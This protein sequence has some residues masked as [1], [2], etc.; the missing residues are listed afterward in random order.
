MSAP[1]NPS[2]GRARGNSAGKCAACI[3]G[4]LDGLPPH[5]YILTG[6]RE[7]QAAANP[8]IEVDGTP[9]SSAY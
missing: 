6:N 5:L 7:E 3:Y 9:L 1:P 4:G 8:R 2:G